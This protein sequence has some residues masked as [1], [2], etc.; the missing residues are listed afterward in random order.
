MGNHVRR[1]DQ[2]ATTKDD[3]CNNIVDDRNR[4]ILLRCRAFLDIFFKRF[5]LLL[6]DDTLAIF[7][8]AGSAG[9]GTN[10]TISDQA[11]D[12][13]KDNDECD[14]KSFIIEDKGQRNSA[15]H[16]ATTSIRLGRKSFA[17]L[18][19]LERTPNPWQG[20]D[21]HHRGGNAFPYPCNIHPNCQIGPE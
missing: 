10:D 12:Q 9:S 1:N 21:R 6:R 4:E 2:T 15:F 13:A 11:G 8:L 20:Q 16:P 17:S 19:R 7:T 5:I 18:R 3:V 14:P